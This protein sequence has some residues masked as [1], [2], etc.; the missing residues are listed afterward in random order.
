MLINLSTNIAVPRSPGALNVILTKWLSVCM[1][2]IQC[3][4]YWTDLV[5]LQIV[6][7]RSEL[8]D[9]NCIQNIFKSTRIL[10]LCS[11]FQN[12]TWVGFSLETNQSTVKILTENNRNQL[13]SWWLGIIQKRRFRTPFFSNSAQPRRMT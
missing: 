4:K 3:K 5:K 8:M 1:M 9:N 11:I 7:C 2:S 6:Y 10:V 13:K 12:P